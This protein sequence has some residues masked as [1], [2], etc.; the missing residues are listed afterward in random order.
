MVRPLAPSISPSTPLGKTKHAQPPAVPREVTS[1]RADC[2]EPRPA[3]PGLPARRRPRNIIEPRRRIAPGVKHQV[4]QD[5]Q[6]S[7]ET[8]HPWT[9]RSVRTFFTGSSAASPRR[10][11]PRWG[12][13]LRAA[14]ARRPRAPHRTPRPP[15]TETAPRS[16][17]RALL[18][19][20][21][22]I[23]YYCAADGRGRR[24]PDCR[25][26]QPLPP[27]PV[28]SSNPCTGLAYRHRSRSPT[29][30]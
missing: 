19:T 16:M 10:G 30:P 12:P 2:R 24:V 21:L 17:T 5:R 23:A 15:S 29:S 26:P 20:Q 22:L 11:A 14:L 28:V 9:F 25:K 6:A 27:R 4:R 8:G 3:N 7:P 1:L 13:A 18:S